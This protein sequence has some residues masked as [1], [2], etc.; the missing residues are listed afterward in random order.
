MHYEFAP[1]YS[2][3]GDAQ[4]IGEALED[5]RLRNHG[6]LHPQDVVNAAADPASPLHDNFEWDDSAAAVMYRRHQARYVIQ[7]IVIVPDEETDEKFKPVRA[8]VNIRQGPEHKYTSL[9]LA[10][11]RPDERAV[12]FQRALAEIAAWRH[13]YEALNE[14]ASV[15]R[16]IDEIPARPAVGQAGRQLGRAATVAR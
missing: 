15:F 7:S 11:S 6:E 3:K 8:F 13:R 4:E 10:L 2:V 1:N 5:V 12:V 9:Q 14:F 16:A